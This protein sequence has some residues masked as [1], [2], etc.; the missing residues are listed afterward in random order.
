MT[1]LSEDLKISLR[2]KCQTLLVMCLNNF[3]LDQHK[4]LERRIIIHGYIR[5]YLKPIKGLF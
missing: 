2:K 5:Q 1:D 3:V 4:L